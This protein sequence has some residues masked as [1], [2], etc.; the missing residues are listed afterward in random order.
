MRLALWMGH[1]SNSSI[2]PT[3][4][5]QQGMGL[6]G[7]LPPASAITSVEVDHMAGSCAVA[8]LPARA[9]GQGNVIGSVSVY[10]Y[11]YICHQKKL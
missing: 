7:V 1:T 4:G 2:F 10:I 6:L 9:S 8:Y 5:A 3:S 11:I